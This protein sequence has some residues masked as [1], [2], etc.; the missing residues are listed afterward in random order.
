MLRTSEKKRM[1]VAF[2]VAAISDALSFGLT[3]APPVQ[4]GVD[5]VTAVLLFLRP[6][7]G[8]PARIDRGSYSGS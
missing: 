3:I 8:D 6:E 4:W 5:L 2:V 1:A 7:M